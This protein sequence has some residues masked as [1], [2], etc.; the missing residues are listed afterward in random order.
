MSAIKE[1]KLYNFKAFYDETSIELKDNHLLLYGENGSG[2][3]SIYWSL[4]TLF[5]SSTKDITEIEKYFD[6]T[7]SENLINTTLIDK[8]TS[9]D[10]I[11]KVVTSPTTISNNAAIEV[12]LMDGKKFILS[13][14]GIE[15]TELEYLKNLNRR[16]DFISHRLLINFY[17]FR[18]S[19]KINL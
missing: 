4:Y 3:S 8:L 13:P 16:S 14:K 7:N 2:K 19:K 1:I 11:T 9:I 10:E 6:P 15:T 5:Q 18:N 12:E 17:N